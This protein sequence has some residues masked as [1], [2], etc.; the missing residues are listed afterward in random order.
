MRL[1][2]VTITEYFIV[3]DRTSGGAYLSPRRNRANANEPK[4]RWAKKARCSAI[5]LRTYDAAQK[6]RQRYGGEIVRCVRV[7]SPPLKSAT[8]QFV[9]GA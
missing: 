2:S 3:R 1:S 5:R 9:V 8:L 7:A 4:Y 6:A